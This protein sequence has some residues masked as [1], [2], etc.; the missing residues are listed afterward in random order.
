MSPVCSIKYYILGI[1]D[2]VHKNICD[3][4]NKYAAIECNTS[5]FKYIYIYIYTY[6]YVT[7]VRNS[8]KRS[9]STKHISYISTI[10]VPRKLT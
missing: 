4:K 3:T 10:D 9:T 2:N 8:Y 1:A 5:H 6:I 7:K